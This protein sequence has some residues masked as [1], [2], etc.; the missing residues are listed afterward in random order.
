MEWWNPEG[1][2]KGYF[3]QLVAQAELPT[4]GSP[5]LSLQFLNLFKDG[6]STTSFDNL[7]QYSMDLTVKKILPDVQSDHPVFQFVPIL[8]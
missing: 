2:F 6:E 1:T 5:G 3:V 8:V 4:A 7:C